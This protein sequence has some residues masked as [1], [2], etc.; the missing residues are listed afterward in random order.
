[1]KPEPEAFPDIEIYVKRVATADIESWLKQHFTV[2][3]L[4]TDAS[5]LLTYQELT[6]ECLVVPNA[7]SGGFTSIWFKS[8]NTPW[9]TDLDCAESAYEFLKA[10]IRCSAGSWEAE[11]G[12]EDNVDTAQNHGAR[13]NAS[14]AG[15]DSG[16]L[17]ID[18]N[19]TTTIT[20][21]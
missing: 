13:D 3:V 11:Q 8:N 19:G 17:K 21:H 6:C 16:W 12:E 2:E 18:S 4:A 9:Q 7:V 1:M 15:D 10:E 20:W 5:Y 14:N